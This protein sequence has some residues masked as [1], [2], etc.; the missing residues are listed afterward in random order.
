MKWFIVLY[1]VYLHRAPRLVA[2]LLRL[3][4]ASAASGGEEESWIS[5]TNCLKIGLPGK[6][7]LS[8]RKG[9]REVLFS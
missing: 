2:S 8:K 5:G 4:A 7:I 6:L 9:L 1:A 3:P